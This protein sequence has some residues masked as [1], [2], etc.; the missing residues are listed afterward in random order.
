MLSKKRHDELFDKAC[1]FAHDVGVFMRRKVEFTEYNDEEQ[2]ELHKLTM[3]MSA[4]ASCE[5]AGDKMRAVT[6]ICAAE[7]HAE[8]DE[9]ENAS[10]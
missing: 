3:F 9:R 5:H 7:S 6:M 1:D 4:A 2:I 8:T 10:S